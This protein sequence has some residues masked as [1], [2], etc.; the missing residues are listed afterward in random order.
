LLLT[1]LSMITIGQAQEAGAVFSMAN[2]TANNRVIRFR[3]AADGRL[4]RVGSI[5][6]RG[7]GIG[8]DLDTTGGLRLS[9]DRRFLYAVNAGSDHI[10]VFSV[11]GSNLT[12]L[13]KVDAGDVPNS[14]TLFRNLLYVL[15]GSVAG[16]GIRGFRIGFDG[17][18]TPL[19]NSF[20]GTE[21]AHCG[22]RPGGVQ[23]RRPFSPRDAQG[24]RCGGRAAE[25]RR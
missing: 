19:R 24:V 5:S 8:T 4:T 20:P 3:R 2:A 1:L 22:P 17:K 14:L 7:N 11:S 23:P 25:Q 9:A 16:N 21:L 12:F 15:N 13:Q 10:T 6:T 18:L